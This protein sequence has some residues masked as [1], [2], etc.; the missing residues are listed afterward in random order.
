ML[1]L[2]QTAQRRLQDYL[3]DLRQT[4]E[5]YRTID[6]AEIERDVLEHIETSL[7]DAPP[8]VDAPALGAVLTQLGRPEQWVPADEVPR[9]RTRARRVLLR[10]RDGAI[11]WA[12][13]VWGGPEYYRLAYLTLTTLA[14]AIACFPVRDGEGIAVAS[15]LASFCCAR[16]TLT[17]AADQL[18]AAQKW[19][20]YPTLLAV[21]VPVLAI[22]VAGAF[23]APVV[24][25]LMIEEESRKHLN[26]AW[27]DP[28]SQLPMWVP[29]LYFTPLIAGFWFFC[30]GL[31]G[32]R[33]PG[34]V[35]GAFFPFANR[36]TGR[37]G[38]WI[39]LL[40]LLILVASLVASSRLVLYPGEMLRSPESPRSAWNA[41]SRSF[42]D[43]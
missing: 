42:P 35:R 30:A 21:Y 1:Q 32:W 9:L 13:R 31:V 40:A 23:V 37:R 25:A 38:F 10:G 34:L 16:A 43:L 41:Q 18:P 29:V 3:A 6:A 28:W 22:L 14:L 12:Q 27:L 15:L 7:T 5:G 4:L 19:L 36:F 20:V 17:A 11:G 39:A 33:M 2:T 8:P 26:A 24:L